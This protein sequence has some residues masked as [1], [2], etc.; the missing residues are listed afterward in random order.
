[1]NIETSIGLPG[2]W[3]YR[4]ASGYRIPAKSELASAQ[5]VIDALM[6]YRLENNIAVG[7]PTGDLENYVCLSFPTWCRRRQDVVPPANPPGQRNV[8]LVIGWANELYTKIGRLQLV[9]QKEADAR[10]ETCARCPMQMSW[11]A[12]CPPCVT[13][14]QRLLTILRQGKDTVLGPTGR[15]QG[16]SCHG[17]DNR[18]AV[19]LDVVHLPLQ[20]NPSAPD[21]CWVRR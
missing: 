9:P 1:V 11:A 17:W 19:H 10:A 21:F 2:G 18:T 16:C 13:S 4:D 5:A 7:D 14:A 8:D 12:D 3:H 20:A 15:L 6:S